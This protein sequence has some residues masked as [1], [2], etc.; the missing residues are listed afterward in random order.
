MFR[1]SLRLALPWLVL[2]LLVPPLFAQGVPQLLNYQ[3]RVAVGGVNYS[4]T[5][6]FK[7]ALVNADGTETYWSND[8]SSAAG[9]EPTAAVSLSVIN[10]ATPRSPT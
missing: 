1:A 9:S 5:G 7:F 6:Q 4:G 2:W 8:G 10:S 3:G